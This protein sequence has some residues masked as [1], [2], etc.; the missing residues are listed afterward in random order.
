MNKAI[1]AGTF[2]PITY[3]HLDIIERAAKLFDQIVVAVANNPSKQPLIDWQTRVMLVAQSV[4]H[5]PNVQAVG[6][7]GLLAEFAS[8]QGAQVLIRGIRSADDVEYEIQLAQLNQKLNAQL[9]SIFL[10]P[11]VQSR[12]LSS[13]MV[14][15]IY[16]HH[17]DIQA[18][19]P[20]VVEKFL[21]GNKK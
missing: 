21:Q 10:P 3:G 17:G 4:A 2:D 9:D 8:E 13:T 18:F 7:G 5:L 16:R 15:E 19:V 20:P 6:F 14:R 1:Y 11:S 12:Y